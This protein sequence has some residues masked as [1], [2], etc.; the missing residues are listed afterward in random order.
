M[1]LRYDGKKLEILDQQLLPQQEKWI[2]IE[3]VTQ[4]ILA[5]QEL[6]VRGAPLIGVA[7]ALALGHSAVQG[8]TVA[9]LRKEAQAL[10][11][12]RPT[13]VNLMSAMSRMNQII[14][15]GPEKILALAVEIFQ[16][17]VALCEQIAR[18]GLSEFQ[19]GD[20]I[21]TH[22]NSGGLATAGIGT[23]LGVIRRVWESGKKIHVYVDETRPLLQG[24]RL[25]AWELGKLGIPYTLIADNMAGFLMKQG[26]I[27]K[28]VLGADRIA[29]N[30]DF[31]NKIGTYSVAVLAQAHQIPFY[32]AAPWTT[33]D[34]KCASGDQI[35]I[36]QRKPEEVRGVSGS[37]GQI[38]WA[39][40][41][42]AVYNP[43][44]DVTPAAL[45]QG[46]IMDRG[47]FDQKAIRTGVF[48]ETF[49]E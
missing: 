8:A 3:N 12:A 48:R 47:L 4:M 39:P 43:A 26:R 29:A 33:V 15:S 49:H 38:Q 40:E 21:L 11:D 22:C 16:E 28:V 13:A 14:S 17:D 18:S 6:K 23:A 5:I 46:W 35:P 31:A 27:Q 25:T 44:F 20:S 7:A 42:A 36:E 19:Q 9:Q 10:S 24:G 34:S 2:S 37:F 45:V 32:V 30:G 1:G 41:K